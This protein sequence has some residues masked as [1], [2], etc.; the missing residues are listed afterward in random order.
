MLMTVDDTDA[1]S[2]MLTNDDQMKYLIP[3]S[4]DHRSCILISLFF[5]SELDFGLE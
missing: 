1:F 4:F 2:S 5:V 3:Y